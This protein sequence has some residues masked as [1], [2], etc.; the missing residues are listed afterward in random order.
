MIKYGH[1]LTLLKAERMQIN[2]KIGENEDYFLI[3]EL[4]EF[5]EKTREV[6][7]VSHKELSDKD[8][9]KLYLFNIEELWK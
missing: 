3:V 4:G 1:T 6:L 8:M 7:A 9:A 2:Q 5:F